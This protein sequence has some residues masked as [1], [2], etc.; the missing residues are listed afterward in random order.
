MPVPR[1]GWAF[2]HGYATAGACMGSYALAMYNGAG[3]AADASGAAR[4]GVIWTVVWVTGVGLGLP[5]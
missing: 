5:T 1:H 2:A 4:A 3:A